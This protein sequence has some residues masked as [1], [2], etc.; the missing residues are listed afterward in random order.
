MLFS[1]RK[2]GQTTAI[3]LIWVHKSTKSH[4]LRVQRLDSAQTAPYKIHQAKASTTTLQHWT[5]PWPHWNTVPRHTNNNDIHQEPC[6]AVY[7]LDTLYLHNAVLSKDGNLAP[8]MTPCKVHAII[9]PSTSLTGLTF[10]CR[11]WTQTNSILCIKT[12]AKHQQS[13]MYA[14]L[15]IHTPA[16]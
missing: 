14:S 7:E 15:H 2:A 4:F 1:G 12:T 9:R 8:V 5:G 10:M 6:P 11:H 13:W 3:S 16:C